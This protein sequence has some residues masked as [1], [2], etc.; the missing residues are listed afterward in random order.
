MKNGQT[1]QPIDIHEDA[2]TASVFSSIREIQQ[3][4]LN[5]PKELQFNVRLKMDGQCFL[6]KI[7]DN[8]IPCA[9]FDPQL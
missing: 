4:E 5:L 8:V 7:P 1:I 3:P 6:Q 2:L 9:F